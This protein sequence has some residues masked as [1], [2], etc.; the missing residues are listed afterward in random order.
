MSTSGVFLDV[1]TT[2]LDPRFDEIVSIACMSWND[3]T[4]GDVKIGEFRA[5]GDL[6]RESAQQAIK[7]NGYVHGP[8]KQPISVDDVRAVFAEI[9]KHDGVIF[10][11]NPAF[12]LG[13]L[14][15][16]SDRFGLPRPTFRLRIIDVAAMAFPLALAGIVPGLSLAKVAPTLVGKTQ[17]HRADDDVRL[18]CDVFEALFHRYWA[19]LQPLPAATVKP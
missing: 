13:F 16:A 1:E 12:D 11:W 7:I 17:T 5:A 14:L 15:A 6:T 10:G 8:D 9:E 2:G 19:A 4:R 3:G 18:T